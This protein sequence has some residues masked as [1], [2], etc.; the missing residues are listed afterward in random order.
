MQKDESIEKESQSSSCAKS[1][2]TEDDL[3]NDSVEEI[4]EHNGDQ[5]NQIIK[6]IPESTL[7]ANTG[8]SM[9]ENSYFP[10]PDDNW[11]SRLSSLDFATESE[12]HKDSAPIS[13]GVYYSELPTTDSITEKE[14][15][16]SVKDQPIDAA[17]IS[18]TNYVPMVQVFEI[19]PYT[20]AHWY[21]LEVVCRTFREQGM[22]IMYMR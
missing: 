18:P 14:T 1:N 11:E 19:E 6:S 21:P 15:S 12:E 10:P 22:L 20:E 16:E 5:V 4:W 8:D 13:S 17:C 7:N 3:S 2:C 9:H